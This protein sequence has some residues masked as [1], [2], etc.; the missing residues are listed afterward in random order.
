MNEVCMYFNTPRCEGRCEHCDVIAQ[1]CY[2]YLI[3]YCLKSDE[4]GCAHCV[5]MGFK[6]ICIAAREKRSRCQQIKPQ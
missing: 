5:C 6:N 3:N 1:D 4:Y 2:N